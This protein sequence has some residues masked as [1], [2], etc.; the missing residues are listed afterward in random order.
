MTGIFYWQKSPSAG[1]VTAKARD[2][3]VY[4]N[5]NFNFRRAR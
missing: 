3:Q 4:L 1:I 2:G 5:K